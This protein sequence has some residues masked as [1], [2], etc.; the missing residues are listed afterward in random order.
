MSDTTLITG[1]SSGIGL[2]LAKLHAADGDN[3]ILVAR[4]EDKLNELAATLKSTH[5]IEVTVLPSDLSRPAAVAE[6]VADLEK[7]E[8]QVDTLVNNAGFGLFGEFTETDWAK[9]Q[10]M[11]QLNITT[12]TELTKHL[13]PG[14]VSRGQGRILNL[15]STAAFQPGPLMAVYYATKAYVLSFS[16]AIAEEVAG[17]GVTITA[18]CPGA[19]AS[20]F[21]KASELEESK[22]VKGRSL[23]SAREVAEAGHEALK[24]G[25]R[26]FIPGAANWVGAQSIRFMPRRMVTKVVKQVQST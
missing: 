10:A 17:T 18:F 19:T 5:G 15:A 6:L 24:K 11:I 8:L 14:M 22:L 16:E 3:L 20:G 26:V 12:L 1:A 21:Q 13:L 23:P 2:E 9:E 4:S 25:R 7:R